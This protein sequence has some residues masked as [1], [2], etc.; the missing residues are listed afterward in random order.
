M[1]LEQRVRG[2]EGRQGVQEEGTGADAVGSGGG[3]SEQTEQLRLGRIG[4]LRFSD[5]HGLYRT[6]RFSMASPD[7]DSSFASLLQAKDGIVR[8]PKS[9]PTPY[10]LGQDRALRVMLLGKVRDNWNRE[11]FYSPVRCAL[12]I[13]MFH[14]VTWRLSMQDFVEREE[15]EE[16]AR[17]MKDSLA[18]LADEGGGGDLDNPP[19]SSPVGGASLTPKGGGALRTPGGGGG[20]CV[21]GGGTRGRR[22]L[23]IST[24]AWVDT[25]SS[26]STPQV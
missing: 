22:K 2:G 5:L 14:S 8:T 23:V 19:L 12:Q 11:V 1:R 10:S 25:H 20:G 15:A 13:P 24:S 26:A 21:G 16:R 9:K 17:Q 3:E 7:L 18:L 4:Q 6:S